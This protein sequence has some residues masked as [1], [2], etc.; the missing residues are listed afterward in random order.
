MEIKKKVGKNSQ[1]KK[2]AYFLKINF[3]E[4]YVSYNLK[5][6]GKRT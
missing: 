5:V 6:K 2:F 1:V 3:N 4:N